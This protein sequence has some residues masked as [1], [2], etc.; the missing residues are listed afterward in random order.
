MSF[1]SHESLNIC[2]GKLLTNEY[3]YA[4]VGLSTTTAEMHHSTTAVAEVSVRR[5][6]AGATH[7]TNKWYNPLTL[8]RSSTFVSAM[9]SLVLPVSLSSHLHPT[10]RAMLVACANSV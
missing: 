5:F 4:L 7:Q 6:L 1:L 2:Q 10:R 8:A 3:Y 9:L